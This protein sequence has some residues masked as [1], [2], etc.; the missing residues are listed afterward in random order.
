MADAQVRRLATLEVLPNRMARRVAAVVV[1]ATLTALGAHVAVPLPGG[2][3]VTMQTLFVTLAGALLGPYLGAASQLLYLAVGMAGAP[4]F[5][6]GG[7]VAYLLGPTGGY[8]L[9]YP[10]AAALT[11]KLS[12]R[13][14]GGLN[15]FL[16]IAFAMLIA[17]IL[18]LALGWAQLSVLTGDPNRALQVGVLPFLLGDV[19]KVALGALIAH[20][21]RAR[22]LGL[23]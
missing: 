11:G 19:L 13:P 7:G 5:A 12:G 2:V 1:F 16:Q 4:V 18:T 15:G 6:M 23:T 14:K 22:T 10:L 21:L 3:P 8:L 9:S 17:S 20:R